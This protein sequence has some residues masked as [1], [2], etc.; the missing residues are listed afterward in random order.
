MRE[1]LVK[2]SEEINEKNLSPNKTEKN[3]DSSPT[4]QNDR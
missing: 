2:I 1:R 3:L 4:A